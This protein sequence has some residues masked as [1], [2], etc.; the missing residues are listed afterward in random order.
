MP[1]S[2]HI[3]KYPPEYFDVVDRAIKDTREPLKITC[4]SKAQANNLR[5]D[6]Y[7]FFKALRRANHPTAL[8]AEQLTLQVRDNVL[9]IGN[10]LTSEFALILTGLGI[11]SQPPP[12]N[13]PAHIQPQDAMLTAPMSG[14]QEP[15]EDPM[16]LALKALGFG[17]GSAL[18]TTTREIEERE[19]EDGSNEME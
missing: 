5:F 9:I 8:D 2:L 4:N 12:L 17:D 3:H 16:S 19:N 15:I 11:V 13:I 1:K 14:V 18:K 10:R 7:A 6:L